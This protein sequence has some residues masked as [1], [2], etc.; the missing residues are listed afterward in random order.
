MT[1]V[2]VIILPQL[3]WAEQAAL[4]RRAEEYGFDHAWTYDHLTWDPLA[5][6]PWGATMPT[7][8]AAALVTRQIPLGTWVAS[9]NYRHPVPFARELIGL[10]DISGGRA[11]LGIGAGG[12]GADA[13]VLGGESLSPADRA[14][15][16]E[17]FVTL[18]DLML[19]QQST[20]WSGR[21]Y[22][23]QDA[24]TTLP[25]V[26]QPRLPFVIAANGPRMM[27]L[28]ARF[29]RGW[30]TTGDPT[31]RGTRDDDEWWAGVGRLA[32][33]FDRVLAEEG[34]D[35]S[36]VDRMLSLDAGPIFSL[37][38]AD[39]FAAVVERAA[40]LGFTDVVP[41]WPI[42]GGRI[43]AG[44]EAVLDQV[45]ARLPELHAVEPGGAG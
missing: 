18:L 30:A 33:R 7:L 31:V 39:H 29:G 38:S 21:F 22:A 14:A 6:E 27:R 3:R 32:A 2:G 8:T 13:V 23:A 24:A 36:E 28:A 45:A 34:R 42:P 44:D 26:Q 12:A 20:S 4:W 19:R 35:R 25:C 43:Y 16:L 15:R 9:P 11:V 41:H 40:G 37:A 17:E 10:D 5:G 1:K